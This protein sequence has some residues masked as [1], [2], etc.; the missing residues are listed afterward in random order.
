[1]KDSHDPRDPDETNDDTND[2]DKGNDPQR[3]NDALNPAG[4]DPQGRLS[5]VAG[6]AGAQGKNQLNNQSPPAGK[7]D[8]PPVPDEDDLANLTPEDVAEHLKQ[9]AARIAREQ[10][11]NRQRLVAAPYRNLLDW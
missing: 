3:F 11:E 10:R 6:Q 1:R 7:G 4:A 9:A 2:P 5:P 8:L